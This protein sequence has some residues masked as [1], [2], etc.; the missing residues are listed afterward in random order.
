MEASF[1]NPFLT[2]CMEAFKTMFNLEPQHKQPYLLNP[3][4][5]NSWEISGLVAVNGE[6]TGIVAFRLHKILAAKMLELS[7]IRIESPEEQEEMMKG[8]V[9]EFT[10]IITGNAVSN[11][12]KNILVSAPDIRYGEDH[13]I[14]WPR[15][16]KIIA[17]PFYTKFGSFE[18]DLCFKGM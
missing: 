9:E 6:E 16:T 4:G 5:N 8:L 7:G 18:V 1:L 10:N 2:A 15:S 11:I 12:K 17:V 3:I 14:P 13:V